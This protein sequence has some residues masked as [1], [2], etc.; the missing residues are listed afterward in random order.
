[1]RSGLVNGDILQMPHNN[2]DMQAK[3]RALFK[4][5]ILKNITDGKRID[6]CFEKYFLVSRKNFFFDGVELRISRADYLMIEKRLKKKID[7]YFGEHIQ[8]FDKKEFINILQTIMIKFNRNNMQINLKL[9]PS[10]RI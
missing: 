7:S 6:Q 3:I 5:L 10:S 1:M 4:E 9:P 2:D 8:I